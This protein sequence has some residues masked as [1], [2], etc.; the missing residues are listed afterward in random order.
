MSDS[1]LNARSSVARSWKN[2]LING[3]VGRLIEASFHSCLHLPQL[4]KSN[5]MT[6]VSPFGEVKQHDRQPGS[7]NACLDAKEVVERLPSL[8]EVCLQ[9]EDDALHDSAAD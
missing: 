8:K 1:S 4:E 9:E 3:T 6:A 2:A 7:S 5:S